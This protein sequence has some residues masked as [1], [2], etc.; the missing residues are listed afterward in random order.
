MAKKE[1]KTVNKR[2]RIVKLFLHTSKKIKTIAKTNGTKMN[3]AKMEINVASKTMPSDR[4]ELSTQGF[5]V[6]CSAN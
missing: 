6:L 2:I 3:K 5:S 1:N 4:I